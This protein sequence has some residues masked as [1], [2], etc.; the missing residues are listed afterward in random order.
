MGTFKAVLVEHGYSSVEPEREIIKSAG[1]ELIDCD[2]LPLEDAW[3]QCETADAVMVRRAAV[4]PAMIARLRRCKILLR[5]GVGVDNID[6]PAATRHGII[7]GHVPVYCQDEV[8]THAIAL[9]LACVRRIVPTHEKMR[10]GGWDLHRS[11]PVYRLAGQTI[12]LVGFGTLAQAVARKL[13]GW[14]V[15][16][17]ATDPYVSP[18]TASLLNVTLLPF[19][20]LLAQ[21]DV[22]S[23]HVPLVRETNHLIDTRSLALM[24][25][26]ANLINTS[27]GPVVDATALLDA[28]D[29]GGIAGAALDVFEEEPLA[30]DSP[31]R[32]HPRVVLTDHMAWYSEES[33]IELQRR[34]AREVVRA[35]TGQL[36]E[37]IANPEVLSVL[38]RAAEWI[39]N[40]LATWQTR[41][42][43]A[44]RQRA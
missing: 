26:G 11:D 43:E 18:E 10:A 42:A 16:L 19:E 4:T 3:A 38:G 31:L 33:Q 1:G 6:L 30:Q 32:Q 27:R 20:R 25:R 40:H 28:L 44:L 29:S 21:S 35:C 7:V 34:A 24:K 23:L 2:Q 13:Q 12:G 8:S 39:P 36:P 41:R 37:A 15:R 14:D 17:V 9:M 22:V 5:Y